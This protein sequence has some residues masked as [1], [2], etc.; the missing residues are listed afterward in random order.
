MSQASPAPAVR[1]SRRPPARGTVAAGITVAV[2]A[3]ALA[4]GM[5]ASVTSGPLVFVESVSASISGGVLLL[6][7]KAPLGYAVIAGMVAAV[8]PCGLVLLPAYLGLYLGDP[9]TAGGP[10]R[11]AVRAVA[12]SATMTASFVALFGAAGIIAG[13]AA[14]AVTSALPWIGTVVGVGLVLLGGI[15]ASGREVGS[16]LGPRAAGRFRGAAQGRGIRGYAAYGVAYALA[17][18]GCT[19]PVFLG[20]VATSFQLHGVA[21]AGGQFMLFGL[22]MGI[23]LTALTA[24]TAVIGSGVSRPFRAAARHTGWATAVLLWLAGTYLICYWLTAIRLL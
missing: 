7:T 18:L 24:A 14:S 4:A 9:Q 19:L 3:V 5:L 22:G 10:G 16:S 12:I 6:G 1:S 13:L 23:V 21:A 11:R 20:V 2:L 15:M 17:S 8:N